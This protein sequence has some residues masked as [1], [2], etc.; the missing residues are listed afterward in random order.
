MLPGREPMPTALRAAT[1]RAG[2]KTSANSSLQPLTAP[3]SD[4]TTVQ[5]IELRLI[6]MSELIAHG[7]DAPRTFDLRPRVIFMNAVH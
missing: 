2:P 7:D 3:P 1:P 5:G 6:G 4:L